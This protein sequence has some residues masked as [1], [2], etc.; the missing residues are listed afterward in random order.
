VT[1]QY[2]SSQGRR[3]QPSGAASRAR[4]DRPPRRSLIQHG[5]DGWE[6]VSSV[7]R[8]TERRMEAEFEYWDSK[9]DRSF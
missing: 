8:N 7:K 9:S 5:A 1:A 2:S 3:G 4:C 6:I